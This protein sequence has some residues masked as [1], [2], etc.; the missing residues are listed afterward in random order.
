MVLDPLSGSE[1]AVRA[2]A[3]LTVG[4]MQVYL[5]AGKVLIPHALP[6]AARIAALH[7]D[8]WTEAYAL[9]Y[10]AVGCA[11]EGRPDEAEEYAQRTRRAGERH[12]DDLLRGLAGLAQGWAWLARGEPERAVTEL[13][14]A[15]NLGGDPHQHHFV[16]VY[17][18]LAQFALGRYPQAAHQW[19]ASLQLSNVLDNVRG[20]AGSMEG[21]G[22]LA[23]QA[24]EWSTA[25]RLLAA[26]RVIRER[27][28]LPLFSFWL[29]QQA[30]TLCALRSHLT[31]AELETCSQEG[32]ALRPEDAANEAL[33]LLRQ[34]ARGAEAPEAQAGANRPA[35]S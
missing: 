18:A 35:G 27:T 33:A 3:L 23:C 11:S 10:V 28:E 20:M 2:R 8:W 12:A 26:A 16:G 30:A 1:T 14:A 29:P 7:G 34:Y 6:E 17:I 25:A 19:L 4:V 15:R 24:G 5:G 9:G 31:E 22:Y 21:C 32:A 13:S